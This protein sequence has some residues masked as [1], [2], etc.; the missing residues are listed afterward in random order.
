MEGRCPTASSTELLFT[1]Q[2]P[3]TPVLLRGGVCDTISCLVL[4]FPVSWQVIAGLNDCPKL[5]QP[6]PCP[7]PNFTTTC[8]HLGTHAVLFSTP[9]GARRQAILPQWQ[10]APG[11]GPRAGIPKVISWGEEPKEG[12]THLLPT[13]IS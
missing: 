7:V 8:L 10:L 12:L 6:S 9:L 5:H 11:S 2:H 3:P 1:N 13:C 4:I